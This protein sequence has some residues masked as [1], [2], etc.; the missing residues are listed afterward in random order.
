MKKSSKVTL[1]TRESVLRSILR[2]A[3]ADGDETA[4]QSGRDDKQS[5]TTVPKSLPITPTQQM[6]TQLSTQR[7]PVEDP[8]FVPSNVEELGRSLSTL[9][10]LVRT[11]NIPKFYKD[12]VSL[13]DNVGVADAD[14][15]EPYDIRS[16]R[17]A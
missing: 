9:A 1:A 11:E 15:E 10:Q 13:I 12:F 2:E 5:Q 3:L 6:A 17:M 7:P 16:D 14:D 4:G 8:E